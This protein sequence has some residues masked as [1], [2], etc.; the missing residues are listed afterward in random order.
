MNA[1]E[2]PKRFDPK[3]LTPPYAHLMRATPGRLMPRA[4]GDSETGD[5]EWLRLS[6]PFDRSQDAVQATSDVVT[7]IP[8]E[9]DDGPS[10]LHV[11]DVRLQQWHVGLVPESSTLP[12]PETSPDR[13]G[14]SNMPGRQRGMTLRRAFDLLESLEPRSLFAGMGLLH[15]AADSYIENAA[16][17]HVDMSLR[18]RLESVFRQAQE[19]RFEDGMQSNF[20]RAM[21]ALIAQYGEA[22]VGEARRLIF[23]PRTRPGVAAEALRWV[24]RAD[25]PA[26][27]EQRR[28]VLEAALS[29]LSSMVRDGAVLGLASLDDSRSVPALKAAIRREPVPEL[30]ADM[31]DLLAELR[32]R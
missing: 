9:L 14:R 13:Y 4:R 5:P 7:A 6:G 25:H 27:Q 32:E 1:Q 18:N 11:A 24:A 3:E 20:G 10:L 21:L 26:T 2:P 22:S 31:E 8:D 17:Q 29:H 30:R 28:E 15:S 19:E 23:D 12:S 16:P